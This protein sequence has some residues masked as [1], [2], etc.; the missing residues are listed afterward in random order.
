MQTTR[1]QT[2]DSVKQS[3]V[4]AMMTI[5]AQTPRKG[6]ISLPDGSGERHGHSEQP[7]RD[8]SLNGSRSTVP[9]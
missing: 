8:E 7:L 5:N 1:S 6:K 4:G 2:E 9:P 3:L